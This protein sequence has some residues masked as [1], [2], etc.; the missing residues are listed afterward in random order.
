MEAQVDDVLTDFFGE[1]K[2]DY[3]ISLR[4]ALKA[5]LN[6]LTMSMKGKLLN[7]EEKIPFEDL[8]EKKVVFELEAFADNDEKAFI[9]SLLLG[10]IYQI[11]QAEYQ[12]AM[13]SGDKLPHGLRH[14]VVLEE[15]HRL[16][17]KSEGKGEL[18]ANPRAKAV[19]TF[20]DMLAEVRSYGQGLIIVDQIPSK[21]TP[22]VMK[23]TEV[24][25]VH[26]L[27]AKDDRE[28]V[29][30]TMNLQKDQIEDLARHKTG[31]ATMYF[32]NLLNALH[33]KIKK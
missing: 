15:A 3:R 32:G 26:R 23:N 11:R 25:I 2:S 31:E 30:A 6:S 28:V 13:E 7:S 12:R 27:L 24:K 20:S 22:E 33:V 9:M 17:A 19:E 8:M 4:G 29:G 1:D 21:L 5:R 18:Q 14:I 16:L 10:R